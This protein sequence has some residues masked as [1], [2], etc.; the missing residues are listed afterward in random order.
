MENSLV[1]PS[2][3][4]T[5]PTSA[6]VHS[7]TPA[8]LLRNYSALWRITG[9]CLPLLLLCAPVLHDLL[10]LWWNRYGFSH[11]FLVPLLS[12]YLVRLQWPTLK[13]LPVEPALGAGL[14][15]LVGAI[16]LLLASEVAGILTTGSVALI[17]VLAGLVLLLCG[18][19]YLRALAFPLAYL[20]FMTP[21]LDGLTEP[22]VWP[23]QLLTANMSVSMLRALGIPVILENSIDIILPTVT[24]E[25]ARECS[26]A[27]LLIAVLAIGLPLAALTLQTW[28]ARVTLLLSSVA[29]AIM[30]NW[31]RL[32]VMGVYAQ[33][34]G[35][36]LH[37]P[38]HILQGL[39]VDWVAFAFLFAGAWL[40]GRLE[41]VPLRPSI[42]GEE[43]KCFSEPVSHRH[44]SNRAWWL[45]CVTLSVAT[46]VLY[47]LDRGASGLKKE[48][49]T[50]PGVVGDWVVDHRLNSASPVSLAAADD[51][52]MRTYRDSDGRRVN[53]YVA[54]TKS[55]RQGKE[56]VGMETA[57]LHTGAIAAML[58]RREDAIAVNR[59]VFDERGRP[60][61]SLF[62]YHINGSSY[63]DRVEAKLATIKQALL[64]GRTDGALVLVS[65]EPRSREND[66]PWKAQE[67]FVAS[68]LPLLREYLP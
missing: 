19:A 57:P 32:T 34:G 27:G 45:A 21:V 25:V 23:F 43:K 1:T 29:I 65:A 6:G 59:T 68:A 36:D 16:A 4:G 38:Y 17:L 39:F 13:Q 12:L 15:W 67:E 62:W 35:K 48:L 14:L 58:G 22:L 41:H 7:R 11:G 28:W 2:A 26:G 56:L 30:A 10:D 50:F 18:F 24:L 31:L 63:T 47:G 46:L 33:A 51:S 3:T 42:H 5:R 20:I 8:Y 37:G 40:L 44:A 53:V 52:L 66:D 60:V 64:R 55:Q 61:P 9:L 54:Y 49:A